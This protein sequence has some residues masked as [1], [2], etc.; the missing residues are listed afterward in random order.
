M[1]KTDEPDGTIAVSEEIEESWIRCQ[2]C[3]RK[4][5]WLEW[6]IFAS[7]VVACPSCKS[8]WR[9]CLGTVVEGLDREIKS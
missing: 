4:L 2:E 7:V 6:A 5:F 8:T 3:G 1:S 9:I